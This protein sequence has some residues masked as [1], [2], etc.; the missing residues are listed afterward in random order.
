MQK[1][2]IPAIEVD[3]EV[4]KALYNLT[5]YPNEPFNDVLRRLLNLDLASA[6][7]TTITAL[8][9]K[10]LGTLEIM[11]ERRGIRVIGIEINGGKGIKV[12]KGGRF[13]KTIAPKFKGSYAELRR[14]MIRDG[15]LN[16]NLE[17]TQDYPF[18]SKSAAASVILGT[19]ANGNPWE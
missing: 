13:S 9:A 2:Q 8:P 17:L 18:N 11:N 19:Q 4:H 10:R 12:L 1:T 5:D 16:P 15:I 7:P 3:F 6:E 14:R